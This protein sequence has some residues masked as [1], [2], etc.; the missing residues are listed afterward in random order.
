MTNPQ[1]ESVLARIADL[2]PT[3]ITVGFREVAQKRLRLRYRIRKAGKKGA[4][5]LIT[6]IVLGPAG[7]LYLVDRHH[8]ACAMQEEGL[9]E[10]QVRQI[11]DLSALAQQDLWPALEA[12]GWCRPFDAEGR[13]QPFGV[14]F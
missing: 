11:A 9:E 6:P 4:V 8:L 5:K 3:Q 10:V 12:R 7:V 13:R 14:C 1:S 2:H